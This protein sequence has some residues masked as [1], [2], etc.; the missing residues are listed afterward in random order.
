MVTF[1][2]HDS[3]DYHRIRAVVAA[4]G[5][6]D[7]DITELLRPEDVN[8]LGPKKLAAFLHR[9]AGGSPLETLVRLFVLG[10]PVTGEAARRALA[11]TTAEQ[12]AGWGLLA[13]AGGD[14]DPGSMR[15]TVSLRCY[16][17]LV[18]A[19]DFSPS[20][21]RPLQPDF[22]MGISP[23]TITLASLTIRHKNGAALDLGSGSGFQAFLGA[24]HS[25]R[26]VAVDRNPRAVRMAEFNAGLNGLSEVECLEGDM[27]GPVEGQRFDLIVSNPPFIISPESRFLFLHSGLQGDEICRSI[28]REAP[29]FL[30]DGGWCQYMANWAI[31]TGE[32]PSDRLATWF[33]DSGCD[34]WVMRQ[35]TAD[36]DEYAATWVETGDDLDA[37]AAEF[38]R[39]MRHFAEQGIEGVGSGLITMR[40]RESARAAT[41][42]WFRL[43]DAPPAMTYPC[44]DDVAR[45]FELTDW[46]AAHPGDR[47]LLG[48][49]LRL[50]PDV[51]LDQQYGA[52]GGG[53]E[54]SAAQLRRVG[55]LAYT[56]TIDPQGAA[57]LARCDGT[58][59]FGELLADL[60][61]DSGAD[62]AEVAPAPLAAARRMIQWGFLLPD[63]P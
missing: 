33:A 59:R 63:E 29:R 34:A 51:R 3:S 20:A 58:R 7:R 19:S 38:D 28:A 17:Q 53:W 13:P 54:V 22:V 62:I 10:V 50:S 5:Y 21:T 24:A 12:W 15:A 43:D 44:G 61:R 18:V 37:Y 56:G 25:Q 48:A 35:G 36:P 23:S 9:T 40:R 60:A 8:S 27:F 47:D 1:H 14:G 16:Q 57:V 4:A 39:W 30:N 26:V 32:D 11:P 31:V 2:V 41:G 45:A 55:G 42:P 46:L 49:R 6:T 52:A